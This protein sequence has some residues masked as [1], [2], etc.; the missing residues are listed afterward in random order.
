MFILKLLI[1]FIYCLVVFM[2]CAF[3]ENIDGLLALKSI[4][5]AQRNI[6]QTLAR[7]D[8][9][10]NKLLKD[11]KDGKIKTGMS[12]RAIIDR[13][14]EPVLSRKSPDNASVTIFLYR[15]PTQY[16]SS[17][18]VYLYFD[19]SRRLNRWEYKASTE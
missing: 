16:F 7:Q 8:R 6:E 10:F 12:E 5:E 15:H 11:I 13:Y 18:K 14:G 4:G 19:K 3:K 1:I 17:N 2:G 9:F